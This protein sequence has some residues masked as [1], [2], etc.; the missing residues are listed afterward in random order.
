MNTSHIIETL[1]T[2]PWNYVVLAIA[3][4]WTVRYVVSFIIRR[5]FGRL[6]FT[7]ILAAIGTAGL[8]G[9][10]LTDITNLFSMN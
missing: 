4:V 6:I 2:P 1:T 8:T 10:P 3:A 7:V 5:L 9:V